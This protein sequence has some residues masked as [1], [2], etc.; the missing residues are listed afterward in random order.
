MLLETC[1]FSTVMGNTAIDPLA[2][3]T[4]NFLPLAAKKLILTFRLAWYRSVHTKWKKINN[5]AN[6]TL[7]LL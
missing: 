6:T 1:F 3:N 7:S 4:T 2:R 5:F